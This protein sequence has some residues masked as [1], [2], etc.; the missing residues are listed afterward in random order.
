MARVKTPVAEFSEE[1]SR[2]RFE[3]AIRVALSGP[4]KPHSEMKLGKP[5]GKKAK[6]PTKRK[7]VKKS[8]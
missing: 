3:T 2:R 4:A 7:A 1:E 6:S 8:P 5:R